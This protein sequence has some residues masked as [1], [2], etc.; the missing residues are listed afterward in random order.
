MVCQGRFINDN[1]P[2]SVG[3]V[4]KIDAGFAHKGA[5]AAWEI[6]ARSAQFCS[7]T[8]TALKNKVHFKT[9]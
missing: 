1:M 8:K 9:K 6:Y 5:E 2:R 3:D 4:D 7:E